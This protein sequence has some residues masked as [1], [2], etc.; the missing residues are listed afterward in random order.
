[1]LFVNFIILAIA[2]ILIVLA[3]VINPM[4]LIGGIPLILLSFIF[5]FGFLVIAP[6]QAYVLFLC[7]KY[8]GTL[9]FSGYYWVNPFLYCKY[10][11]LRINNL[12][13]QILTVNDKRGNPI[14]I[15]V[16]I[17]WR[18]INTA[19]AFLEVQSYMDYIRVQSEAA[20]RHTA[21]SFSY[22]MGDKENETTF[23]NSPEIINE[24]LKKELQEKLD[25]AGVLVEEARIS[26]LA[27]SKVVAENMLRR[28]IA[29]AVIAARK[30]IVFGSIS[31]I[32]ETLNELKKR[33][34]V[35]LSEEKK[36]RLAGNLLNILC[37]GHNE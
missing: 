5:W 24:G 30:K 26:H 10:V 35:N 33:N 34:I 4:F 1:M 32:E 2:V 37:S 31:M 17:V 15:G 36:S 25:F 16:I 18:L 29:D 23:L 6:N 8:K 20:I 21:N 13:S 11:S 7:S 28:Q 27:Y 3:G 12:E 9:K 19:K 14:E 22:D